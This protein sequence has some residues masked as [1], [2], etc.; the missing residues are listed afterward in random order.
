MIIHVKHLKRLIHF[1]NCDSKGKKDILKLGLTV[2]HFSI[3]L[4]SFASVE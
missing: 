3:L 4:Y 2:M 1:C